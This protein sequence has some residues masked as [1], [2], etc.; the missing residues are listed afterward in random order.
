MTNY[1]VFRSSGESAGEKTGFRYCPQCGSKMIKTGS[2]DTGRQRCLICGFVRYI[3]PCPGV[4][5][6]IKDMQ[7]K[8]LIGKR[9]ADVDFPGKWCLPGGYIE[10]NESFIECA[11]RE[12]MEETGLVVELEGIVNVVSNFLDDDHHTLVIVLTGKSLSEESRAGDD[13]TDLIWIT[14]NDLDDIEFAFEADLRIIK[15]HFKGNMK[16]IPIDQA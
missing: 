4:V 9:N 12:I 7:G 16:I 2:G 6:L 5:T 1:H 13:M 15:A 10:N 11:R 8:I 14:G 3:N